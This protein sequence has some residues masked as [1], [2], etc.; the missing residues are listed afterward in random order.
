LSG[1]R[2]SGLSFDFGKAICDPVFARGKDPKEVAV[3][4]GTKGFR[5]VAIVTEAAGGEDQRPKLAVFGFQALERGESD[6]IS[7]IEVVE[8]FKEF[9]FAL[10]VRAARLRLGVWLRC[11]FGAGTF[12]NSH[13]LPASEQVNCG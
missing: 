7:A 12:R 5:A 13:D 8:S 10:V 4:N 9:G 11:G 6:A 3:G 2:P 1:S